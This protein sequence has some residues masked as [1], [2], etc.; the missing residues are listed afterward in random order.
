MSVQ[1]R[2]G[3]RRRAQ[4]PRRN[5]RMVE[6]AMFLIFGLTAVAALVGVGFTIWAL[7]GG[8][9]PVP[10]WVGPVILL[11]S[12]P[13]TAMMGWFLRL[14]ATPLPALHRQPFDAVVTGFAPLDHEGPFEDDHPALVEVR[15][16]RDGQTV[17]AVTVDVIPAAERARFAPGS[18]WS[19]YDFEQHNGRVIL[20]ED[21]DDVPRGGFNLDGVRIATESHPANRSAPGSPVLGRDF[22]NRVGG[23]WI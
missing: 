14:E 2:I 8:D 20:T 19:V 22:E 9:A 1:D 13:T 12:G 17:E 7:V 3:E 5:W 4:A 21:H 16:E 23:A 6:P 11:G 15:F 10:G 18:R